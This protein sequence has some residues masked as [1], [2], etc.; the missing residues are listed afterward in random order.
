MIRYPKYSLQCPRCFH[1]IGE[2]Y[3]CREHGGEDGWS[4]GAYRLKP[5]VREACPPEAVD[6]LWHPWWS[7]LDAM[8]QRTKQKFVEI[9]P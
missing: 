9:V 4:L 7:F 5:K 8:P 6:D 1:V 3:L 2:H